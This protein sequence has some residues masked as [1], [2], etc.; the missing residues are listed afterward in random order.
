MTKNT[1]QNL[2]ALDNDLQVFRYSR[3]LQFLSISIAIVAFSF[4]ILIA[5]ICKEIEVVLFTVFISLIYVCFFF[6]FRTRHLKS[7]FYGLLF[8][9]FLNGIAGILFTG[10]K[11]CIFFY[12]L[13]MIPV[14]LY[15]PKISRREITIWC[16]VFGLVILTGVVIG[17][18]IPPVLRFNSLQIQTMSSYNLVFT[19]IVLAGILYLDYR[20]SNIISQELMEAN[21]K[22]SIQ[23]S[24][25]SLTNLLNRRT[26]NQMIQI[27]HVRSKRSNKPFGLIM[28]DVDDFKMVNDEFGHAAGDMVLTELSALIVGTLRKQDLTARWGGEEFLILLPETDFEGVQVIAEKIRDLVSQSSFS[29]QGKNIIVT[30]SIGGVI[31]NDQEDW[32][33]CIRHADRALYYGKN[34]GKNLAV[35]SKGEQYC[36][37]GVPREKTGV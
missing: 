9:S 33:D 22:L 14:I 20:N 10:W 31:C 2:E 37:L 3:M 35:F 29:F 17:F 23:A 27:E 34:H 25:D 5:I 26:M 13:V 15:H 7:G 30:L 28:A 36:I 11:S 1:E 19:C 16:I 32:D 21:R 8:F 4:A 24:R 12:L 18:E 6:I